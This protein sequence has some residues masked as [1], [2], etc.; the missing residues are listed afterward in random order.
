MCRIFSQSRKKNRHTMVATKSV[1]K[2]MRQTYLQRQQ[3][4]VR[5]RQERLVYQRL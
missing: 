3:T 4:F 1:M 5:H 2:I